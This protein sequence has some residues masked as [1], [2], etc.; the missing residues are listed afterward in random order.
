MLLL[1]LLTKGVHCM[2]IE[3]LANTIIGAAI[4]V[5]RV[6][7]PGLLESAYQKCLEYELL[8]ME[9]SLQRNLLYNSP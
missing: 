8:K 6:L 5:H 3:E 7:G 4:R 2:N 1:G 9:L